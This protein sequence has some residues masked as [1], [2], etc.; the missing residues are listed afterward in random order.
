MTSEHR[1]PS[2]G[3]GAALGGNRRRPAPTIDLT[4]TE[5]GGANGHATDSFAARSAAGA[6]AHRSAAPRGGFWQA[7]SLRAVID[8]LRYDVAWPLIGAGAGGAV[9]ALIAMWLLLPAANRDDGTAALRE[10]LAAVELRLVEL[11]NRPIPPSV[12]PAR[13]D[14]VV[15]RLDKIEKAIAAPRP[16]LSDP[17]LV[18]QLSAL[19][20]EIRAL[21]ET[22]GGFNRRSDQI[23]SMAREAQQ[24]ADATAVAVADLAEKLARAG[25][26]QV[27]R[28]EIDALVGRIATIERRTAEIETALAKRADGTDRSVRLVIAAGALKAAVERGD[29]Y[30]AELATAKSLAHDPTMLAALEPFARSGVP[31]ATALSR[32]LLELLPV[33]RSAA[34]TAPP[35]GSFFERLQTGAERLVRIRPIGE[36]PGDDPAAI[37]ARIEAR[38]EK[39]DIAGT[40]AELNKL[41]SALRAPA[42][43][44]IA[45]AKERIATLQVSQEFAAAALAALRP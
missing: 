27:T 44:W 30:V 17:A 8:W 19:Q 10:R 39:S 38:A 20:G 4:A 11:A 3:P 37:L 34:G 40:L 1:D 31:S 23:A 12:D 26:L 2:P 13:L 9:L 45:K 24:K 18:N 5:I 28:G 25:K 14:A 21:A 35:E 43:A 22:V 29:P 41:P 16:P 6:A 7:L 42:D 32:Q 36:A 15:D 33:L